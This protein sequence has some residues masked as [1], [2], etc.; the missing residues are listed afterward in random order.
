MKCFAIMWSRSAIYLIQLELKVSKYPC[1]NFQL[2]RAVMLLYTLQSSQV[3]VHLGFS[4]S[5]LTWSAQ[6]LTRLSSSVQTPLQCGVPLRTCRNS[7]G[8]GI[9][10]IITVQQMLTFQLCPSCSVCSWPATKFYGS[11]IGLVGYESELLPLCDAAAALRQHW[12]PAKRPTWTITLTPD[13][14]CGH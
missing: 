1:C 11:S 3:Q 6:V 8:S 10:I 14:K 7:R 12:I 5:H 4:L 9:I 13:H 2:S